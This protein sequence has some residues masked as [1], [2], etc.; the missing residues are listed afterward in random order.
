MRE[1]QELPTGHQ[2]GVKTVALAERSADRGSHEYLP[3]C[4]GSMMATSSLTDLC[5]LLIILAV[6]MLVLL[7]CRY[8]NTRP[9]RVAESAE[10][11][12]APAAY[13]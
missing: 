9:D 8:L 7:T 11:A 13:R 2:E 1:R 6:F 12:D 3:T 10:S 4:P 5:E